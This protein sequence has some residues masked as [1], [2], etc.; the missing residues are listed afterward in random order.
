M[1]PE[2]AIA[3]ASTWF[4][5]AAPAVADLCR[6]EKSFEGKMA[7]GGFTFKDQGWT[8]FS[9]DRWR[10]WVQRLEEVQSRVSDKTTGDLVEKA[11]KSISAIGK[12]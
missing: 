3:A 2:V 1:V 10:A 8:G 4:V 7:R 9:P 12:I 5:F 11:I 6:Q